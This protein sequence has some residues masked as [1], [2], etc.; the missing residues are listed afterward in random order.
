MKTRLVV[1]FVIVAALI[2]V[3]AW[4]QQRERPLVVSGFV[5][6]DEIRLG[7]RVGGRVASV[8]VQEGQQVHRG[9][10]LVELE[11]FDL[12]EREAQFTAAWE[13][14]KAEY[15]KLSSGFRVEER[16]QAEAR[17]R[18]WA[19]RLEKLKRGPRQQEIDTARAQL[20][21]AQAQQQLAEDNYE[22]IRDLYEQK[23]TT[24][25]AFARVESE[26]KATQATVSARQEQ[27]S[28]LEAGTRPEEIAEAEAQLDEAQQAAALMQNGY[29]DEEVAAAYAAMQEAD[30]ALRAIQSQ[31]AELKIE[32]PLTGTV[33]AVE[34]QPGDLVSANAPVISLLDRDSLWVR[35]YVPE[36]Q[37]DVEEG[38]KVRVTVDS[39]PG[40]EFEGE[41][42]FVARQAEFTPR[43]VQTP[44]ERSQQ[45]FRI[46]VVLKDHGRLRP[47]MAAD[48]WLDE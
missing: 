27:L 6:A 10:V 8:H 29:R 33:E 48:V 43:N 42:S 23:A 35:A 25:E 7:S 44:E 45:V 5:E 18:Q 34:L 40:E 11:P 37:L 22:R 20:E 36:D 9:D 19:A 21:Q 1:F 3:L 31:I 46:K 26:L 13:Q 38:Q 28:L 17:V 14:A 39:Y 2:A 12:R 30:A 41:I 47:G 32:A 16:L 15:T 4:S 24:Q